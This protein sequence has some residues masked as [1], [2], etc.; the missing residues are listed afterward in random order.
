MGTLLINVIQFLIK[1]SMGNV[2]DFCVVITTYNRPDMLRTLLE[3]ILKEKKQY[4]VHIVVFDDGS[5]FKYD[6]SNYNVKVIRMFPNMGKQKYYITFNATFSYVKNINSKYFIYLPDDITL[7]DDFFSKVKNTYESINDPR[8][9]CLSILTDDRVKRPNW[10]SHKPIDF[11]NY[12]KTQWND[13]CFISEKGFFESLNYKI[14][15]IPKTRWEKNPNISSGV[16]H[17][18]SVRLDKNGYGMY[19]TKSSMVVHGD[20]ESKMNKNERLNKKLITH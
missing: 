7:V 13:L 20:H 11:G 9:I 1:S 16:G 2:Y 4:N 15:E 5:D 12:Y 6:L 3:N 14:E 8:K 18:I 17:Q 19:H 10:T